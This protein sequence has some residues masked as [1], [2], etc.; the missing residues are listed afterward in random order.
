L[1]QTPFLSRIAPLDPLIRRAK[2]A[3]AGF[4]GAI[5][6]EAELTLAVP[7]RSVQVLTL[8]PELAT[9]GDA[10]REVLVADVDGLR[11]THLFAEDFDLAYDPGALTADVSPAEGGYSITVTATSFARDVALLADKVDPSALV[12]DM[13]VDL[14]PGESHTFHVRT[15]WTDPRALL[16]P[17][18]LCSA[19]TLAAAVEA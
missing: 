4:D 19:N 7:A 12:D 15:A 16:T 11:A 14:L 8:A 3:R 13:L 17:A 2:K 1:A 18:V 9:P 6:T 10:T 5:L